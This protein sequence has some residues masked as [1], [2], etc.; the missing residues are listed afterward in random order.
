[1][2]DSVAVAAAVMFAAGLLFGDLSGISPK[3]HMAHQYLLFLI[4]Q[5]LHINSLVILLVFLPGLL[6]LY[7]FIVDTHIFFGVLGQLPTFAFPMVLGMPILT[8][9]VLYYMTPLSSR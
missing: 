6:Y 5:W 8:A 1:M 9:V 4:R 2:T 7:S 3:D